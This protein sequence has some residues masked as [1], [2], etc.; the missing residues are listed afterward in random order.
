[1]DIE[2][3]SADASD[4]RPG[5]LGVTIF[6]G[7][8]PMPAPCANCPF[9]A[10]DA[11]KDYLAPGRLDGI[12]FAVATGQLFACHKTVHH[13]AVPDENEEGEKPVWHPNYRACA[14]GIQYAEQLAHE[15]GLEPL[16]IG[17]TAKPQK[18]GS[19]NGI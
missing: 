3:E 11:G 4:L 13:S 19:Y 16:R 12:K 14:G 10:A 9:K 15:L 5:D 6:Y 2:D 8:Q 17:K 1:M 18:S 7:H